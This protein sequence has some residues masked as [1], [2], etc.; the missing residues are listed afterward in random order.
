M[1]R[2]Y[3]VD[4]YAWVEYL[5]GSEIGARV[6]VVLEDGN[7]GIYTCAV[8]LGEVISK[9]AREEQDVCAAYRILLSNS[10]V[11]DVD[12]ELSKQTGMIHAE[13]RKSRKDFGLADA[14]VLATARKLGARIL[15]GD[16]HFQGIKEATLV[17]KK[18]VS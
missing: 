4:A 1:T 15:T 3:V 16:P 12:E 11:I 17:T 14:F 6:K 9:V 13:M 2:E 10:D 7:I 5:I 8:T 18:P